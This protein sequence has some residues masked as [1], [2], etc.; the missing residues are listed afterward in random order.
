MASEQRPGDDDADDRAV[1]LVDRVYRNT[2]RAIVEGAY[3]P[4]TPLRLHQLAREN[5]VSLI[6]VREA[7]RML[8]VERLVESTPMKGARVAPISAADVGDAYGVRLVLEPEAVRLAFPNL[9]DDDLKRGRALN[10]EMLRRLRRR[11]EAA[12]DVHRS[13]HFT[14]Y[15]AS[16]SPWLLHFI[17]I[18]WDATERYRRI[19]TSVRASPE[20]IAHEHAMVFDAIEQGDLAAA[21]HA[22]RDHLEH[23]ARILVD[24]CEAGQGRDLAGPPPTRHAAQ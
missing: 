12:F 18:A 6:P 19:A 7:L 2:R 8:E 5:D 24:L 4:G 15:E 14:I 13:L 9:T 17:R 3:G 16:G 20:E 11:D 23:T 22:L 21:Q 1:S 10:T